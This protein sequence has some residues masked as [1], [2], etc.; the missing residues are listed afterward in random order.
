M[1]KYDS[2]DLWTTHKYGDFDIIGEPYFDVNFEKVMYIT[3]TGRSWNNKK[4]SIRDK[5]KTPFDYKFRHTDDII[6]ALS[7]GNL[8]DQIMINFHPQ[9]WTNNPILWLQ[10]LVFQNLKNIIKK[11]I[12]STSK[13]S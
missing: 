2:N 1:S 3:D 11:I 4:F 7:L 8:P 6:L 13:N 12:I 9:R 5:V 10:E